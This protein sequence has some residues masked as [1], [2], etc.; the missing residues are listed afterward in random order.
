[1]S[2]LSHKLSNS[3]SSNGRPTSSLIK[4]LIQNQPLYKSRITFSSFNQN[5]LQILFFICSVIA[6]TLQ[7]YVKLL[8]QG[9]NGSIQPFN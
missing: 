9:R 8:T 7:N 3:V 1:M 5:L 6:Q 4:Y 2:F